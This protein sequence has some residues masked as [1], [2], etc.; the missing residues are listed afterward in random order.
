M[1]ISTWI[2]AF[3]AYVSN[4]VPEEERGRVFG[5][6]NGLMGLISFPAPILGAF[7]Y[8]AYGFPAPIWASIVLSTVLISLLISV[9]ER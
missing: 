2:H 4:A 5:E 6:F 3:N 9:R 8:E 1:V 7:L